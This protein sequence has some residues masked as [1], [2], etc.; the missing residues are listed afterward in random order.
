M[1]TPEAWAAKFLAVPDDDYGLAALAD[2]F[3]QAIAEARAEALAECKAVGV[4]AHVKITTNDVEKLIREHA[5]T[6]AEAVR[7]EERERCAAFVDSPE[8]D[9]DWYSLY[10]DNPGELAD[11]IRAL[12]AGGR[13]G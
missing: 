5:P 6:F 10:H 7:A 8:C 3:R 1:K 9:R 2:L 12:P 13:E 11:A 4:H